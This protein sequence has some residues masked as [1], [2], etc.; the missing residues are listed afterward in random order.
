MIRP[1]VQ[2]EKTGV[3]RET[4]WNVIQLKEL[5]GWIDSV[6]NYTLGL[7]NCIGKRKD[8]SG[9]RG[10]TLAEEGGGERVSV[11]RRKNTSRRK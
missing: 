2:S 10:R 7:A 4:L 11:G 3:C 8:T 1:E 5:V 6:S 9:R